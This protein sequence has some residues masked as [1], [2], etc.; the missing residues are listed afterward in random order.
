MKDD[1]SEGIPGGVRIVGLSGGSGFA[2][3]TVHGRKDE[4]R[5]LQRI[6]SR[7]GYCEG[8]STSISINAQLYFKGTYLILQRSRF[9]DQNERLL[10]G[11]NMHR[12]PSS[13]TQLLLI[14]LLNIE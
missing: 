13:C 8:A 1:E 9:D 2:F 14:L 5:L 7:Y 10:A 11:N 12:I 6:L 3:R 4:G